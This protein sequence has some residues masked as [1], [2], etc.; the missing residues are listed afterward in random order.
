MGF[1]TFRF[2][3]RAYPQLARIVRVLCAVTGRCCQ[4]LAAAVAVTVA[5]RWAT[6]LRQ[7][8]PVHDERLPGHVVRGLRGQEQRRSAYLLGRGDPAHWDERVEQRDDI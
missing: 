2:S 1:P 8:S 3:G 7:A 6:L 5:V 4:R